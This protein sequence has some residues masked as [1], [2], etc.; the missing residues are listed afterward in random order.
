MEVLFPLAFVAFLVAVVFWIMFRSRGQIP[1]KHPTLG[2]LNLGGDE[3]SPLI[4]A[5]R[6]ALAPIFAEI[7]IAVGYQIP[8]CD[9]L[10]IY[11]NVTPDGSVGLSANLTVRHLAEKAGATITVVASDNSSENVLAAAKLVGPKQANLVWTLDRKGEAFC[12]FFVEL[13]TQMKKGKSMPAAWVAI[14]PQVPSRLQEDKNL[15]EMICNLEAGQVR[16]QRAG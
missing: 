13:F 11:A 10:F 4:D 12:R 9:I 15:P 2:F 16:F 6:A 14:S 5:D 1:I 7:K 8:N 3:F